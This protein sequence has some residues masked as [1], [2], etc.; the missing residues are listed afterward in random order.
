MN[1]FEEPRGD[2]AIY[3]LLGQLKEEI[4][5]SQR[6]KPE[7]TILT[8]DQVVKILNISSRT[9]KYL[10]SRRQIAFSKLSGRT[11]ILLSDLLALLKSNRLDSIANRI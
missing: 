1:I 10:K 2:N 7:E 8:E 9:L 6:R 4:E 11:Y 5:A 3:D